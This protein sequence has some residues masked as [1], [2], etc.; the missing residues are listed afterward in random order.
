M[1][2]PPE[3]KSP[4]SG[5][6]NRP[7]KPDTAPVS[8]ASLPVSPGNQA[9]QHHRKTLSAA[10]ARISP[11]DS[12][13]E[14]KAERLAETLSGVS[15]NRLSP[16][17]S[18]A[19]KSP[20][21]H[22]PG[23][24]LDA[25]TPLGSELKRRFEPGLDLDYERIR[26]HTGREAAK[27]AD[28]I[29]ARAYTKGNDV[30]FGS[31]QYQPDTDA[32]RHLIAHELSHVAD[33]QR[34]PTSG[35]IHRNGDDSADE[36]QD[37]DSRVASFKRLVLTTAKLRL[38]GNRD[39]LAKW[40]EMVDA[41]IPDET[42]NLIGLAQSGGLRP[43]LEMQDERNPE[44]R[45]LRAHQA[46]GQYRLCTGCHMEKDARAREGPRV[47]PQWL[48]P[49]E[50][51]QG[52]QPSDPW[53]N[54]DPRVHAP[55]N[56]GTT[57][58][59]LL[60]YA[61]S[62]AAPAPQPYRPPSGSMEARINQMF[63]D[64]EYTQQAYF[65]LQ[66]ILEVLGPAGYK[67]LPDYILIRLQN[68]DDIRSVRDDIISAIDDR[69]KDFAALKKK[70]DDGEVH[71]GHFAPIIRDLLA[72][73]D[74]QVHAAITQEMDDEA[75]WGLVEAIVVGIASIAALL[76]TIFPPTTAFGIGALAALELGLGA[77]GV[78]KGM[79]MLD[80][81]ETYG[82]ATGAHDVF[83]PEQQASASGLY[84]MGFVSIATGGLSWIT[85]WWRTASLAPRFLLPSE[86]A[87]AQAGTAI[88]R[89]PAGTAPV[90]WKSGIYTLTLEAEGRI[91]ATVAGRPDLLIIAQGDTAILYQAT[92]NG[93]RQLTVARLNTPPAL[94]SGGVAA[95]E[96]RAVGP[97]MLEAAPGPIALLPEYAASRM[98]ANWPSVQGIIGT[99]ASLA[100]APAGYRIFQVGANWRIARDA[101]DDALFQRLTVDE[102]GLIQLYTGRS[103]RASTAGFMNDALRRV[104]DPS[105]PLH[106]LVRR[107]SNPDG[108]VTYQ[109]HTMTRTT[110]S[111][112]VQT[113]RY[114]GAE[115]DPVV[116]AGHQSAFAS[117]ERQAYMLEDADY[118][119]WSGSTVESR[120]AY[121]YKAAVEIQGVRVDM[122]TAL[123]YERLGLLNI[124]GGVRG[125]PV[126]DAPGL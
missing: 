78:V 73:A 118:N 42:F 61:A 96:A 33:H 95:A 115:H 45:E 23:K 112:N 114:A 7:A 31:G 15:Q 124:E 94:P 80:T 91:V 65:A 20:A 37:P 51:R 109:W 32:G 120:G 57:R 44:V 14:R 100:E 16:L 41:Q 3:A 113:G 13:A 52:V 10:D 63:P 1:R 56:T 122:G 35:V 87:A 11:A 53:Y 72:Q 117:G 64:P 79:E 81:A 58:N 104:S 121:S 40:A 46:V 66:P 9:M 99:P 71:Y 97:A 25:G 126:I 8:A 49:N 88:P 75:F 17:S 68:G 101:A 62:S 90:T 108:S 54:D 4:E 48:S 98:A 93:L 76:L 22:P 28:G 60:E 85:G 55:S 38:D 77:Y 5:L 21:G 116:Q 6:S 125:L 2:K 123:M 119:I 92:G 83:T 59:L 74:P 102:N 27:S 47:G 19:R 34:H 69:K 50:R 18:A 70:I 67:V 105:H 110:R 89:L 39:N 86:L 36:G 12:P 82:L 106:F 107:V 30:V 26:L 29:N 103:A 84:L 24:G 111:G 43:Y